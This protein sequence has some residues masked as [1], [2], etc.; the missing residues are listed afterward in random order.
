MKQLNQDHDS[1]SSPPQFL[2]GYAATYIK[3]TRNRVIFC[4]ENITKEV[5]AEI[6]A[7]LLYYDNEDH[8]EIIELYIHSNG[9]DASGLANIYDVMQM[10][11]APIKTVCI[12][13]CYSAGAIM[14][15][16]GTKG[17]RCAF[18]NAKIMIHGIQC[19]FPMLG[20]DVSNS[21]DYCAFLNTINDNIMKMLAK[22]TGQPFSKIKQDCLRDVFM[23]A[24]EAKKYGIIDHILG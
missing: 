19:M 17:E 7:L 13:K 12:G 6:A 2:A 8:N 4:S 3:L 24:Q 10:I 15:A 22:H 23:T 18:K 21:K 1:H 9:G 20:H 14:L 5:G 11:K 16:A